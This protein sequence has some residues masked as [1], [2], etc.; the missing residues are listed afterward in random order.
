MNRD[1]LADQTISVSASSFDRATFK[2]DVLGQGLIEVVDNIRFAAT[3]EPG[4]LLFV[5]LRFHPR[6]ASNAGN[7]TS[8]AADRRR[9]ADRRTGVARD[10]LARRVSIRLSIRHAPIPSLEFGRTRTLKGDAAQNRAI[11][12][13]LRRGA[14]ATAVPGLRLGIVRL[15]DPLGAGRRAACPAAASAESSVRALSHGTLG[16]ARRRRHRGDRGQPM[17]VAVD[18]TSRRHSAGAAQ[19]R[20]R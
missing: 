12:P 9:R 4:T 20:R 1:D 16:E 17:V 19:A 7:N 14:R 5:R 3:P 15:S 8:R 10:R 6:P 11:V 2:Y 13:R 18:T